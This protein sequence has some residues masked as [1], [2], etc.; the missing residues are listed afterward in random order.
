M[1]RDV[2]EAKIERREVEKGNKLEEIALK[3]LKF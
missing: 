1:E 2:K 3:T